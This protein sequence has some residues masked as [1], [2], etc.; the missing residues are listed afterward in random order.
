MAL[1]PQKINIPISGGLEGSEAAEY[2]DPPAIYTLDNFYHQKKSSLVKRNGLDKDTIR[3]DSRGV[4]NPLPRPLLGTPIDRFLQTE[5]EDEVLFASHGWLWDYNPD[6]FKNTNPGTMGDNPPVNTTR[7]CEIPDL[8]IDTQAMISIDNAGASKNGSF[9]SDTASAK[10]VDGLLGTSYVL[11]V[12]G[13]YEWHVRIQDENSGT[14]INDIT[15]EA[16]S[17][18]AIVHP[19]CVALQSGIFCCALNI[20]D[21]DHFYPVLYAQLF[22]ISTMQWQQVTVP[23]GGWHI[24]EATWYGHISWY[25]MC[26][27]NPGDNMVLFGFVVGD[28]ELAQGL[29]L[30]P[31]PGAF[32]LIQMDIEQASQAVIQAVYGGKTNFTSSINVVN[33][34]SLFPLIAIAGHLDGTFAWMFCNKPVTSFYP[35]V[36]NSHI[37]LNSWNGTSTTFTVHP[38]DDMMAQGRSLATSDQTDVTYTPVLQWPLI[39]L[40][41]CAAYPTS[42]AVDPVKWCGVW[43]TVSNAWDYLNPTIRR[44]SVYSQNFTSDLYSVG[45]FYSGINGAK[46]AY[47]DCE[48]ISIPFA[49]NGGV[50]IIV[51]SAR[52]ASYNFRSVTDIINYSDVPYILL[53][54]FSDLDQRDIPSTQYPQK[55]MAIWGYG[56]IYHPTIYPSDVTDGYYITIPTRLYPDLSVNNFQPPVST[57]MVGSIPTSDPE[58]QQVGWSI[59][60]LTLDPT[61]PDRYDSAP[62]PGGGSIFGCANPWVYDGQTAFEAGFISRPVI[63]SDPTYTD[64]APASCVVDGG[65]LNWDVAPNAP[66]ETFHFFKAIFEHVDAKGRIS[67]SPV[68]QVFQTQVLEAN[69]STDPAPSPGDSSKKIVISVQGIFFTAREPNTIKCNVYMSTDGINYFLAGSATSKSVPYTESFYVDPDTGQLFSPGPWNTQ[70]F[71]WNVDIINEVTAEKALPNINEPPSTQN[72]PPSAPLLYTFDG[73]LES[74]YPQLASHLVRWNNRIFLGNGNSVQYSHAFING[75]QVQFPDD[76]SEYLDRPITALT[77]LDDRILLFSSDAVLYRSG[78]GPAPNGQ[79]SSYSNWNFL[80]HE[81]GTLNSRSVFHTLVGVYFQSRRGLE[82]MDAGGNFIHIREIENYFQ[83]KSIQGQGDTIVGVLSLPRDHQ[84]RILYREYATNQLK[85]LV[86]DYTFGTWSRWHGDW[87]GVNYAYAGD[88][89]VISDTIYMADA[90]GYIYTEAAGRQ[91]DATLQENSTPLTYHINWE[92]DSPWLKTDGLLG[93]ARVWR[94]DIA[95]K[96]QAWTPQLY[97]GAPIPRLGIKVQEATEYGQFTADHGNRDITYLQP[98]RNTVNGQVYLRIGHKYQSCKAY[99]IQLGSIDNSIWQNVDVSGVT[100]ITGLWSEYGIE[101]GTGRASEGE[102]V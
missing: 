87:A 30:L 94:S 98:L 67:R 4:P 77:P 75:E 22:N 101:P 51:N 49:V 3:I 82:L 40:G 73:S 23:A 88:T 90:D 72:V 63:M 12:N 81:V 79:D 86:Y 5:N 44:Y 76:F 52:L 64:S 68:S 85:E 36:Q 37:Y 84:A 14:L 27:I 26:V 8:A 11:T 99:Q 97:L 55:P 93:F 89:T 10:N 60:K 13:K 42:D 9:I 41:L 43:Q 38:R 32:M 102:K 62:L 58:N 71:D 7:I 57:P 20:H 21:A 61:G 29:D 15:I 92:V 28:A 39:K 53:R 59:T 45:Y 34:R 17:V 19:T 66:G 96:C 31:V 25:D 1:Q 48:L 50:Y 16:G 33:G 95:F 6:L 74:G 69:W 18:N 56:T 83:P 91:Y 47:Y 80:N 35:A 65:H 24:G 54:I 78:E 70:I 2:L 100:E 46:N